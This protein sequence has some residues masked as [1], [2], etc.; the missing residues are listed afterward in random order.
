MYAAA[1]ER[2]RAAGYHANYGK[3][4]FSRVAG[5]PGTSAYLTARVIESVPYLGLGLGAQTFTNNVLAYNLG[6]ASK[7][8]E[9]Y[10]AVAEAGELPIQD[11]YW[12]PPEEAMAKMVSVACYFG[13]VD[14]AAFEQRFGVR[15]TERFAPEVAFAEQRGLMHRT[16]GKLRLT[17]QGARAFGGVVALFYSPAVQRVLEER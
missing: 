17:K 9:R 10:L 5:D 8:L 15:F 14:L 12:L 2:L 6:A 1:Y 7:R 13:E 4:G 11:L 16:G 3:N